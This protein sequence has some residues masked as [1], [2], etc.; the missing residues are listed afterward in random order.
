MR[1]SGLVT[2][3]GNGTNAFDNGMRVGHPKLRHD[4]ALAADGVNQLLVVLVA[5]RRL[6]KSEEVM[7]RGEW[8]ALRVPCRKACRR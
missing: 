7:G 5:E 1:M 3:E 4:K 6:R 8:R 2:T